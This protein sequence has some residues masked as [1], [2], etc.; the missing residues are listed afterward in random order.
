MSG[1]T[2]AVG[3]IPYSSRVGIGYVYSIFDKHMPL[4]TLF[5][6][7]GKSRAR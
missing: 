4:S 7:P 6:F 2:H 5:S 3:L 1:P